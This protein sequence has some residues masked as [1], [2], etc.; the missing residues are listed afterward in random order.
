M[1]STNKAFGK[2]IEAEIKDLVKNAE[3]HQDTHH[4]GFKVPG[5][6]TEDKNYDFKND[7]DVL[8]YAVDRINGLGLA[9]EAATTEIAHDQFPESKQE[10]WDGRLE[11]FPGLTVNSDARLREVVGEDTIFGSTQTF[12]DHPHSEEMVAWYSD[13]RETN[14]ERAKK[15]FD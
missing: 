10:I 3:V 2:A 12:I 8:G 14:I 5:S 7:V 6:F 9:V 13:F 15:L 4:I 1:M 11:L